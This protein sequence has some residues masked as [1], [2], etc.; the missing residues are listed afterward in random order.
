M[1][2]YFLILVSKKTKEI[3]FYEIERW[4]FRAKKQNT[5]FWNMAYLLMFCQEY[6]NLLYYR[7]KE[8]SALKGV[9]FLFLFKRMETLYIYTPKIGKGLVIQHG[10]STIITAKEI[11]EDCWINQQVTVGYKGNEAPI[12]GNRVKICAGAIVVGNV[13]LGDDCVVGAGAVV[14]KDV[15]KGAIVAGVP[16]KII[17]IKDDINK[18]G[19]Q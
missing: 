2:A 10:F 13:E 17:K 11:G 9:I 6:R 15:P 12:I 8:Q 3:I 18:I 4:S 1:I 14:T 5:I 19:K 16:A 7:L